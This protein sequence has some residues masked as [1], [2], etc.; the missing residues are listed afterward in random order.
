M[1]KVFVAPG[2]VFIGIGEGKVAIVGEMSPADGLLLAERLHAACHEAIRQEFAAG[3]V[4]SALSQ[5]TLGIATPE[6]L[7]C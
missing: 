2:A 5:C 3:E 4:K 7:P 6:H 1:M